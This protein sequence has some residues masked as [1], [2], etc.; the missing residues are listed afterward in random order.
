MEGFLLI[1]IAVA[2][3]GHARSLEAFIYLEY[4]RRERMNTIKQGLT[5][6]HT[7]SVQTAANYGVVSDSSWTTKQRDFVRRVRPSSCNTTGS[8]C[9]SKKEKILQLNCALTGENY[10][11]S[12]FDRQKLQ[13]CYCPPV[14]VSH[15][16]DPTEVTTSS[17][18][19][20][21]VL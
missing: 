20:Q 13:P 8:K 19:E 15:G 7:R 10:G 1:M 4:G 11:I 17:H 6:F 16:L 9:S 5:Q 12:T 2:R 21:G 14:C 18:T 3:L